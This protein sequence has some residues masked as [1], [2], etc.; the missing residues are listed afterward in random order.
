MAL[1]RCS[2]KGAKGSDLQSQQ[3]YILP[4]H[5]CMARGVTVGSDPNWTLLPEHGKPGNMIRLPLHLASSNPGTQGSE[6]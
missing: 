5:M 6:S 4:S 3:L 1:G 2:F